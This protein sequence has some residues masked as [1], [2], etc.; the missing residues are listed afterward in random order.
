MAGENEITIP[1]WVK[2]IFCM[3]GT[4]TTLEE[5]D[6]L[7]ANRYKNSIILYCSVG[8]IFGL[9]WVWGGIYCSNADVIQERVSHSISLMLRIS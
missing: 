6:K 7:I 1:K 9:L 5:K 8:I 4:K 2:K 3:S